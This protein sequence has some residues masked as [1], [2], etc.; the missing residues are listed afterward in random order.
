VEGAIK[1]IVHGMAPWGVGAEIVSIF[2]LEIRKANLPL[3]EDRTMWVY[4]I[5]WRV[6]T[7]QYPRSDLG[8]CYRSGLAMPARLPSRSS[9]SKPS[10][11]GLYAI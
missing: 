7:V 10:L 1:R 4:Q 8:L 9:P 2:D 6:E 11:L 3:Y 5:H